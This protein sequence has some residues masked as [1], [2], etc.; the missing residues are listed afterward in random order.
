MDTGKWNSARAL[1]EKALDL[2]AAEREPYLAVACEGDDALLAHDRELLSVFEADSFLE[3][4]PPGVEPALARVIPRGTRSGL[5]GQ[6]RYPEP[7][8]LPPDAARLRLF[9]A[10]AETLSAAAAARPLLLILDDLQW[11]DE[12]T[13]GFLKFLLRSERI[14]LARV[15]LVGLYRME[16]EPPDLR[17]LLDEGHAAEIALDRLDERAVAAIVGDM[18]A[19]PAPP[20]L[21]SRFL[22]RQT[23][24]NPF[25]V[26]EYLRAAVDKGLL[27]RDGDGI[28]QVGERDGSQASE[29]DYERLGLPRS[30]VA[31][32]ERRL[33]GLG[34]EA[35]EIVSAAAVLGRQTDVRLLVRMVRGE[36]AVVLEAFRSLFRRQIQEEAAPGCVR[37]THDKLR[38]VAYERLAAEER[39]RLH[40]AAAEAIEMSPGVEDDE[41]VV[42]LANHWELAGELATARGYYLAAGRQACARYAHQDAARFY[43]AY[44]G[45]VE[46]PSAESVRARLELAG[47]VLY[48]QG[49]QKEQL[50]ELERA[51]PEAEALGDGMLLGEVLAKLGWLLKVVGRQDEARGCLERSLVLATNGDA[52]GLQGDV[53]MSLASIAL[54][55]GRLDEVPAL[56]ERALACVRAVGARSAEARALGLLAA[57]LQSQE[58]LSEARD[59]T[60]E[61]LAI[62]RE[63]GDRAGQPWILSNLGTLCTELGDFENGLAHLTQGLTLAREVGNRHHEGFILC[64]LGYAY[65][66][67]GRTRDAMTAY[68]EAIAICKEIGRPSI[69]G[70]ALERLAVLEFEGGNVERA[71][72]LFDEA[73]SI[74]REA[75]NVRGEHA[76]RVR[77]VRAPCG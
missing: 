38:E 44:L 11:A 68:E 55:R 37:F 60:E 54:D 2:P 70:P 3:R 53:L 35:M 36:E 7:P 29:A 71:R 5:P 1:F 15:L 8:D 76:A 10:L 72:G 21:F 57:L 28:W 61:A 16:E 18:L 65:Q 46:K 42:A 47:D 74:Q 43:R 9:P 69:S 59:A 4:P 48:Q 50:A 30:L 51:V 64:T 75:G 20:P 22:A 23:E 62:K 67:E 24:G 32:V 58:R 34:P 41:R 33:G 27:W 73:L 26:V 66:L 39:T 52:L 25:F 6:D 31:L 40:R 77:G 45:L 63:I 17:A 49:R 56:L 13:L 12:L 14:A 19:L